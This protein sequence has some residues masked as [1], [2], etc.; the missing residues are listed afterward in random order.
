MENNNN[1]EIPEMNLDNKYST[2]K[3]V[4][5]KNTD[6]IQKEMEGRYFMR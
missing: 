1:S 5:P 4:I 2:E 3:P 6:K